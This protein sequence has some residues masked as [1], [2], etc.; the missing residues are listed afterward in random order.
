MVILEV[1]EE[2]VLYSDGFNDCII[3]RFLE[4]VMVD[5]YRNNGEF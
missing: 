1:Y 4:R 3:K 5:C 2:L